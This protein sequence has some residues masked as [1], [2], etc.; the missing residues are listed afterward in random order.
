MT[1]RRPDQIAM[2]NE[3]GPAVI[4]E[5]RY[6]PDENEQKIHQE[7]RKA[8]EE[9]PTIHDDDF[10]GIY[11][12][13]E[14]A[15]DQARLDEIKKAQKY[16][17]TVRAVILEHV[18]FSH[19]EN[20][21]WLTTQDR[22]SYTV[23]TTEFDDK[24]N[25]TDMVVEW[26]ED[27]EIRRLAIDVTTSETNGPIAQSESQIE[28]EIK[29]GNLA[30]VKY[31][32]SQAEPNKV[33]EISGIPR[34]IIAMDRETIKKL[35]G[36]FVTKNPREL[37]YSH[38]Q[39]L[40]LE[41]IREQMSDQ[42]EYA[43]KLLF[44]EIE[45]IFVGLGQQEKAELRILLRKA[46]SLEKDPDQLPNVLHTLE[47]QGNLLDFLQKTPATSRYLEVIGKQRIIQDIVRNIIK[48]KSDSRPDMVQ[49]AADNIEGEGNIVLRR[50][51]D[52]LRNFEVPPRLL[53]LA[54]VA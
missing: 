44:E 41:E 52:R 2:H 17:A 37:E 1:I 51:R 5:R 48:E 50:T 42:I 39:L 10:K 47:N 29:S 25:H 28:E 11:T 38:E 24:V 9:R 14:I 15:A 3:E 22:E 18:I 49:Q 27:G 54:R 30:T 8:L 4:E 19:S 36:D 46:L 45:K 21:N 40:I 16:P 12:P 31:F 43:L 13:E 6:P 20:S 33:G 26:I 53:A 34:V 32:K 7:A 35:C 23:Q